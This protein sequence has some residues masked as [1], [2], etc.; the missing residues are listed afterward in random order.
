M[1]IEI[2]IGSPVLVLHPQGGILSGAVQI[3]I[4]AAGF[5]RV[6]VTSAPRLADR[7]VRFLENLVMSAL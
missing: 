5:G 1:P 4:D 6:E 7:L 2:G 3:V